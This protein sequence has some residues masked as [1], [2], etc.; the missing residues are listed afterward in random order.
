[1]F[2]KGSLTFISAAETLV[3]EQAQENQNEK[4]NFTIVPTAKNAI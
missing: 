4:Q 1:M 2:P 3:K